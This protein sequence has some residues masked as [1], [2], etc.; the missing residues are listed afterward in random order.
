MVSSGSPVDNEVEADVDYVPARKLRSFAPPVSRNCTMLYINIT[1]EWALIQL[2][3]TSLGTNAAEG[4]GDIVY[5]G[6]LV[7]DENVLWEPQTYWN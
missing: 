6:I 3:F 4:A 5:T 2:S 1:T 7:Y